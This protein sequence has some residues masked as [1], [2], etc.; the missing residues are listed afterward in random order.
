[1]YP[2]NNKY[3]LAKFNNENNLFGYYDK[4]YVFFKPYNIAAGASVTVE[5][6]IDWNR[7]QMEPSFSVTAW[8][9]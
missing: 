5:T 8:G 7:P 4:G 2:S 3:H 1:M 9:E 6:E